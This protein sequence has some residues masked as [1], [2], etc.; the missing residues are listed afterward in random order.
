M[1]GDALVCFAT[2]YATPGEVTRIRGMDGAGP[3]KSLVAFISCGIMRSDATDA[4]ASSET[5][6]FSPF[7][8]ISRFHFPRREDVKPRIRESEPAT[9]TKRRRTTTAE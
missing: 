9:Q 3:P 2:A 7:A 1:D 5:N 4:G 6:S 8:L